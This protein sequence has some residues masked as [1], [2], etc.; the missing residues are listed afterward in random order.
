MNDLISNKNSNSSKMESSLGAFSEYSRLKST[1][2][3]ITHQ[4][5]QA[6]YSTK[7]KNSKMF[8]KLNRGRKNKN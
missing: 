4:E 3:A 2:S 5:E 6:Q 1:Q 7:M 8:A